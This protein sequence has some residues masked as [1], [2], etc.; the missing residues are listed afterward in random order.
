M[1]IAIDARSLMEENPSGVGVYAF[2]LCRAMVQSAPQH[3][4]LL[5]TVGSN[6]A[7]SPE[8]EK[9]FTLGNVERIHIRWPDKLFHVAVLLG[10]APGLEHWAG[11]FDALFV[12]NMHFVPRT[13]SPIIITVHDLSYTLFRQCLSL[14]RKVWH[15][16]VNPRKLFARAKHLIAVSQ[17]TADDITNVYPE[18][19]PEVTSVIH[20]GIPFAHSAEPVLGLPPKYAVVVS[21]IEPRK[22]IA[23]AMA[24]FKRY[25]QQHP[26]SPL[27]LVVIGALGWKSSNLIE[28]MN[29]SSVIHYFGYTSSGQ[30]QFILEKAALVLYPSLYEGFGFPPLEALQAGIPVIAS[31]VG[32]LPE[33]LAS[34]AYYVDPYSVASIAEGLHQVYSNSQLRAHLLAAANNR[35][36]HFNW[37]IAAKQ[38][39]K[40]LENTI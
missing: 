13:Q 39:L 20:S 6:Q 4:F 36:S 28:E 24:G 12:P 30:K 25:R 31:R 8:V 35:T 10:F 37:D 40:V 1:R 9:L 29:G 34:A 17:A 15:W 18:I 19:S 33:V 22:N 5:C 27:Q 2:E 3:T 32:A 38:T 11:K 14:K 23:A 26:T 21:T 7:P 16:V